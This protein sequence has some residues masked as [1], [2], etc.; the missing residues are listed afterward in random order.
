MN[1]P[2]VTLLTLLTLNGAFL[3][4]LDRAPARGYAIGAPSAGRKG[5][6]PVIEPPRG[7][8]KLWRPVCLY[9]AVVTA[10]A[11]AVVPVLLQH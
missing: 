6:Y 10:I 7:W 11:A 9:G 4:G 2:L 1:T 8:R 5:L 3:V